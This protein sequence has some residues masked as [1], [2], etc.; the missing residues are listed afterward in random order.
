MGAFRDIEQVGNKLAHHLAGIVLIIIGKGKLFIMIEQLLAHVPFH[1]CAHH[2]ALIADVIFAQALNDIHEKKT[3]SQRKERPHDDGAFSGEKR[4][5]QRPQQLR[6]DQIHDADDGRADQIQKENGLIGCV[7]ADKF[8]Q[9]LHDSS[10]D[11]KFRFSTGGGTCM[12]E[13]Y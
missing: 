11:V 8:F 10:S 13:S 9:C 2:M 5:G 12:T 6:I 7:V 3:D 1:V 4:C